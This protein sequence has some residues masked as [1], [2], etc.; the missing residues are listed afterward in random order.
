MKFDKPKEE[1]QKVYED[2]ARKSEKVLF[3]SI[4]SYGK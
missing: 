2:V 1:D 4:E 3:N